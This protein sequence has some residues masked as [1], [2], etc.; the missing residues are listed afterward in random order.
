MASIQSYELYEPSPRFG[1]GVAPVGG[2]GYFWGGRVQD[3]SESARRKLASTI[4]I[5]DPYLKAWKKHP[6][7]GVLP[8]G[9]YAGAC[10]SLSDSLYWFGGWDGSSR[11]NSLHRLDTT[12]LEWRELQPLNQVDG[13]NE[14][15]WMWNG[16][17]P[18][19]QAG[20][21]WWLRHSHWSHSAWSNNINFTDGRRWSNEFH[22]FD[23]TKGTL[24]NTL[25][26]SSP[27]HQ[28]SEV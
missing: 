12:T 9:L 10:T 21:I 7:T 22:V 24:W 25:T 20:C 18:S 5:F 8:P 15:A 1:H 27:L 11:Y 16:P 3:F 28:L 19:R 23:I 17:L 14:K 4:E 6:I 13:P 2:R 26:R